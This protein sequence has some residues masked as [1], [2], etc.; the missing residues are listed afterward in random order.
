M[1]TKS[2]IL[3]SVLII[4]LAAMAVP[5]M[6]ADNSIIHAQLDSTGTVSIANT[7]I[8]FPAAL[9]NTTVNVIEPSTSDTPATL[10]FTTN[11]AAW[12]V[13]VYGSDGGK[14]KSGSDTL[15]WPLMVKEMTTQ[16]FTGGSEI[17]EYASI[18]GTPGTILFS[19]TG[20]IASTNI[21]LGIKQVV[22]LADVA[23]SDYTATIT[24]T[25]GA[26]LS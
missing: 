20:Y 7:S 16:G 25:Y 4:A 12:N 8:T 10:L 9:L 24:F 6:A 1:K 11:D 17:T 18:T 13:K 26:G 5:V 15:T 19:G 14:L 3:F 22:K 2:L 23:H 21:D